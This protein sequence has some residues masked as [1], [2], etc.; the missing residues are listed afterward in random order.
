[1]TWLTSPDRSFETAWSVVCIS[2]GVVSE[3]SVRPMNL[4]RCA[5]PYPSIDA[6]AGFTSRIVP[7]TPAYAIP[8]R[9]CPSASAGGAAGLEAP[10]GLAGELHP[11][12]SQAPKVRQAS[13]WQEGAGGL[14]PWD[15]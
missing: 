5:E 3:K 8:W 6:N 2:G 14:P 10:Q 1:M 11:E 13:S 15:L 12:T 7:S 9:V 4:W